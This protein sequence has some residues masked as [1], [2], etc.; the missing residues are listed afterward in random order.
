MYYEWLPLLVLI[1]LRSFWRWD[2]IGEP[3]DYYRAKLFF[4]CLSFPINRHK[5][6]FPVHNIWLPTTPFLF[7]F[8]IWKWWIIR[9]GKS[10]ND[11]LLF[12]SAKSGH[13][14]LQ[15][16]INSN[17]LAVLWQ[18][19]FKTKTTIALGCPND[20]KRIHNVSSTPSNH[21]FPS[22]YVR[23]FSILWA[24]IRSLLKD[25][26]GSLCSW[27]QLSAY[28]RQWFWVEEASKKQLASSLRSCKAASQ[29][30]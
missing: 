10:T 28:L 25:C 24:K 1:S 5:V 22:E 18:Q 16:I 20:P 4:F 30:K 21:I 19:S 3:Q 14:E 12:L 17:F 27:K 6:W 11:I 23:T 2:I 8:A 7:Q 15:K 29:K 13:F 26:H 9:L